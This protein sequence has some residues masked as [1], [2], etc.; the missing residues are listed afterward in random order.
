M[1]SPYMLSFLDEQLDAV[2]VCHGPRDFTTDPAEVVDVYEDGV[3]I[4]WGAYRH[5][6]SILPLG[7]GILLN[8]FLDPGDDWTLL[9]VVTESCELVAELELGASV[10]PKVARGDLVVGARRTDFHEVV[11]YRVS[12]EGGEASR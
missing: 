9:H 1:K 6:V 3:G 12:L 2:R 8:A 11:V 10:T 4:R 7:N 5:S